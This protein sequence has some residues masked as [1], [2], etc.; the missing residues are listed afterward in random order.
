M[1]R[2][3]KASARIR[4]SRL[5]RSLTL[6]AAAGRGVFRNAL[7]FL[8]G[9]NRAQRREQ[10]ML[11]TAEDVA[12]VMGNMK[13][14]TM[15]VGQIL[16]LMGGAVPE[17]FADRLSTLQSS[18]PPMAP[19]L[20]HRVFEED[21][22]RPPSK[23]FRRFEE[24]P[25]AAASIGQVHRAQL[26]DGTP[27]A[28]KVQYPGV[29]EAIGADLANLNAIFGLAGLAARGFDPGPVVEDL[30]RGIAG[31]LDYRLEV[32][33]QQRFYELFEGHPFIR[34]PRVYPEL[35]SGRV[36]VQE[37]IEGKPF[38]A[39]KEMPAALRNRYAEAIF[40]FTF[41]CI[42]RYGLFQSDPHAGNYLLLDDGSVAFLDFGCVTD[43]EPRLRKGINEL[44]A[45]VLTKD[46]P[47]WR[48]AL[49]AIGYV[50][51]GAALTNEE[52][53]EQM[54]IYYTFI[55]EDNTPFTPEVSAAM[56]RQNLQLTGEVGR[57]NRQ[58]NIPQGVVF[59]QRI[60]FGFTG[61][62]S[63]IRAVGP[64][65]SITAEYVLHEEPCTELG[66]LS[67]AFAPGRW[68]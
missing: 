2:L 25:F 21:F 37:F 31:E 6:A 38:A 51:Q 48:A 5:G 36:L 26:D 17:G 60:T 68:V 52:L 30:R 63:S 40:R 13:G 43:F 28:V 7:A 15:K 58:L 67:A 62:M 29:A 20:V 45:G 49:E 16:S 41:G 11:R 19:G 66:R 56:I 46:L 53:W 9:R 54:R 8:P 24:H 33:N 47:R 27:V 39:A 44:I 65:R 23:L 1:S 57:I 35:G 64:W 12:Q 3:P 55:L 42:H 22:G 18:A 59:T 61:L 14:V 50:P 34:I 32:E 10:A 4:Q